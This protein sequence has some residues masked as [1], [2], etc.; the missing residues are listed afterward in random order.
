MIYS[1]LRSRNGNQSIKKFDGQILGAE[2]MIVMLVNFKT[3]DKYCFVHVLFCFVYFS[4]I[5]ALTTYSLK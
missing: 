4:L 2:Y 3:N 5:F 1:V